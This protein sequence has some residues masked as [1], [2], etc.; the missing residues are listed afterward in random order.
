M[1]DLMNARGTRDFGPEE[2]ILRQELID[3]LRDLFELNGF[4]PLETPLLERY[5]LLVSKYDVGAEILKE[6]FKLK[7]QGGRDL[8]LRYDLTVPLARYMGMNRNIKMPFKRYAI[9]R[10]FRDGPIKLGRYREFW[11]CDCDIIGAKSMLAD[12]QCVEMAQQFFD[13]LGFKIVIEVNNRKLLDGILD[14]LRVPRDK[15][16]DMILAI[17]KLKKIGIDGVEKELQEKGMLTEQIDELLK[18]LQTKGSNRDKLEALRKILDAPRALEGLQELEDMLDY[19]PDQSYVLFSISL[20][21]GFAY[22]TGNIFE[23]FLE[24]TSVFSG[25]LGTLN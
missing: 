2:K 16:V 8:C 25:S 23:V 19:L 11:Q 12:A 24:D 14:Q 20:A 4:S 10:V 9:G 22:Y 1:A 18:I 6:T 7:D 15:Q 5:D 21:R 13:K 17:D 3:S